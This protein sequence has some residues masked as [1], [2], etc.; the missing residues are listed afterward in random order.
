VGVTPRTTWARALAWRLRRQ[1]LAPI[2]EG[3]VEQVVGRLGAVQGQNESAA[4]LSINMRR[5]SSSPADIGDALTQG[6]LIKTF[7]FRG[8]I[9]LMTPETTGIYMALRASSRMWELPSW[10]SYYR[11]EPA[12][13][14]AFRAAAEKALADG[15]L[16][17]AEL[18]KAVTRDKKFSHLG[19]AF[20]G[21]NW[22]LLKALAWQGV[23]CF[24]T[25]FG[26]GM[27]QRLDANPRWQG[28]PDLDDAGI[29]AIA[30][31]LGTYGPAT[32]TNLRYWHS[33]GLGVARKHI[34]GWLTQMGDQITEIE[35]DG[36][37]ALVLRQHLDELMAAP[38]A[39]IIRLLPGI[40]Q[41]VM[42]PGTADTHV[43]PADRR[44]L[45]TRGA[46]MVTLGGVVA[47]TWTLT[48][49]VIG[50]DWFEPRKAPPS[51]A[52]ADEVARLGRVLGRS[53]SVH[54]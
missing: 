42:G 3:S 21:D 5:A 43:T 20:T 19:F 28:L 47:G 10:R 12:D 32:T 15:P 14:P 52:V 7:A 17:R 46:N 4:Q 16:T 39:P 37:R 54:G 13:W 45:M 11:L 18:G 53:V 44:A 29:A 40:D 38:E 9:H 23:M 22:T 2:V 6:R 34:A 1:L 30:L 48:G 49:D 24:G 31:Y 41:W 25:G 8:A 26:R 36:E 33:A 35:I 51:R 50:F 27:F